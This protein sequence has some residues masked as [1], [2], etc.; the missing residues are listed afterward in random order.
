MEWIECIDCKSKIAKR[1]K[2]MVLLKYKTFQ[3]VA[4][5]GKVI[6]TC[7]NCGTIQ[8]IKA[9]TDQTKVGGLAITRK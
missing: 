4:V 9:K 7:R 3:C 5:G 2:G 1:G 6:I 8:E